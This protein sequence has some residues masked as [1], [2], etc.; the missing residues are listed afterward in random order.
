[1]LSDLIFIK[2]NGTAL[3]RKN[4]IDVYGGSLDAVANILDDIEINPDDFTDAS[5]TEQ[6]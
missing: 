1:M 5:D 4:P 6:V 2:R 3:V